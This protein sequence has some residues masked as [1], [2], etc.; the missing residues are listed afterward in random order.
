MSAISEKIIYM[1]QK[2][3]YAEISRQ[4]GV[5]YKTILQIKNT[6]ISP[7][8]VITK[9]INTYWSKYSYNLAKETGMPASLA[10]QVRGGAVSTFSGYI[11]QVKEYL[12]YYTKGALLS[13]T[14]AMD[15]KGLVFDKLK[16][17]QEIYQKMVNSFR[18]SKQSLNEF[19]Q[20]NVS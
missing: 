13:H 3:S 9:S 15:S 2:I 17:E 7:T 4:S 20:G 16:K 8:P 14:A 12:D 18:E 10:Q 1:K 5:A 19:I 11:N 6:G